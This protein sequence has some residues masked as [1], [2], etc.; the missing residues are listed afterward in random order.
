MTCYVRASCSEKDFLT[1]DHSINPHFLSWIE[2]TIRNELS[3]HY[4]ALLGDE[5][6]GPETYMGVKDKYNTY[7][8]YLTKFKTDM[9]QDKTLSKFDKKLINTIVQE[10]VKE[11]GVLF[12][13]NKGVAG[14]VE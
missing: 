9:R 13:D 4:N 2:N 5:G 12:S 11:F 10:D 6:I 3:V 14:G 7:R 1:F 8:E